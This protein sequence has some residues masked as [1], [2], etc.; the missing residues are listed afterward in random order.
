MG[1]G[2]GAVLQLDYPSIT[3]TT[4]TLQIRLDEDEYQALQQLADAD[5]TTIS[6]FCRQAIRLG[7]ASEQFAAVHEA[8]EARRR[9]DREER[10]KAFSLV[11]QCALILH[12][13]AEKNGLSV[14]EVRADARE[15]TAE[16]FMDGDALEQAL[17]ELQDRE[18][19]DDK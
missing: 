11:T 4:K 8:A 5:H 7:V 17:L 16:H 9:I 18:V 2:V 3:M 19:G 14:D 12:A 1:F 15:Y 10:R 6:D 13:M